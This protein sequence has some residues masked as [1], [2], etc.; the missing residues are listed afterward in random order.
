[1]GRGVMGTGEWQTDGVT[2][3]YASRLRGPAPDSTTAQAWNPRAVRKTAGDAG[4]L[5]PVHTSAPN[6][7]VNLQIVQQNNVSTSSI[8][9]LSSHLHSP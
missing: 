7:V 3:F 1:M 6:Y 4:R 9:G 2:A 8:R 5:G